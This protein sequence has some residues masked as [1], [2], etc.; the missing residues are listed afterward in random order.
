MKLPRD[1]GGAALAELL[2]RHFGYRKI[3]QVGSHIVIQCDGPIRHRIAI[4]NHRPLRL[5]TLNAIL[6]AVERALGVPRSGSWTS[7]KEKPAPGDGRSGEGASPARW[8]S[9]AFVSNRRGESDNLPDRVG[10]G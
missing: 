5:G 4:P 3:H 7:L 2:C 9:E 10:F 1:V 6:R 8:E